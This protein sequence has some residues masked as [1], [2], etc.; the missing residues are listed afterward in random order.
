MA[1]TN[2]RAEGEALHRVLERIEPS[3]FGAK[4]ATE[5]AR[6]A[7]VACDVGLEPEAEARVVRAATRF[8]ESEYARAVRDQG[9]TAWRERAFVLSVASNDVTVTLRGAMDLVVGWPNGDVDVVD[10]KRARGPDTRPHAFQ[11]DVYALAAHD[12]APASERVRAGRGLPRRRRRA[13]AAFPRAGLS[14]EA[15]RACPLARERSPR[16]SPNRPLPARPGED[17]PR[18][19]LRLLHALPSGEGEAPAHALSVSTPSSSIER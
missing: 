17:V 15:P 14:R 9:A 12:L 1:A 19:R 2:A 4:D 6:A 3:A 10:Y 18:D 8:L 11:L 13:R 5:R 7:L 16:G